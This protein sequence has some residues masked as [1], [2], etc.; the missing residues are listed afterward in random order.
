[1]FNAQASNN[2]YLLININKAETVQ[3]A[4]AFSCYSGIHRKTIINYFPA[5]R[6]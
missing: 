5:L 2:Y 4:S 3:T 6:L 1:M